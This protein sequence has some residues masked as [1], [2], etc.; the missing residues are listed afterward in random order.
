MITH[1][2]PTQEHWQY[3]EPRAGFGRGLYA[4]V[5]A[6]SRVVALTAD[7]ADSVKM[8]NVATDFPDQFYD[9]GVAEQNLL[10]IAA[11]MA[12]AGARPVAASFAVFNPGRN[13]DQ[14]RVSICYARV[15]V[16]IVGSHA[17]LSVGEDGATHQALEDIAITRVLPNLAVFAPTDAY[18]TEQ[19]L[20]A[21]LQLAG[22]SY[23]R[24]GRAAVPELMRGA[25]FA[26]G[27]AYLLRNGT[28]AVLCAHG[29]MVATALQVA[30]TLAPRLQLAV[31]AVPSLHQVNAELISTLRHCGTVFTLEDHQEVGGLGGC[32]TEALAPYGD[33]RVKILGVPRQFGQSGTPSQLYH[34]YG[35]DAESV[36]R[37]VLEFMELSGIHDVE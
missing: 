3:D 15:P 4:A 22:P 25:D 1:L 24:F 11:G 2:V 10:G 32:I 5:A 20:A 36:Q 23:I 6:D 35:L 9:V 12:R 31:V 16:C 13:W 33:T 26:I 37:R 28:D 17:G 27:E 19:V 21:A 8:R 34:A 18:Q 7:L 30:A 14:L 29:A